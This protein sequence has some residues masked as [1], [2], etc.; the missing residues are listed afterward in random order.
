MLSFRLLLSRV[1]WKKDKDWLRGW[2]KEDGREGRSGETEGSRGQW[3][4]NGEKTQGRMVMGHFKDGSTE[5][6]EVDRGRDAEL[7]ARRRPT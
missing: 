5:E 6:E 1:T 3:R 2:G 7:R 4:N